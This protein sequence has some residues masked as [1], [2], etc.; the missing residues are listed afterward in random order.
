MASSIDVV[1]KF[2]AGGLYNAGEV[3]GY[4]EPEVRMKVLDSDGFALV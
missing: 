4:V 3:V 2:V 1:G